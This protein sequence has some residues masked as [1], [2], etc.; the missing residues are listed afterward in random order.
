MGYYQGDYYRGDYYG[1]DPGLFGFL[2]GIAKKGLGLIGSVLPGPLGAVAKTA[3]RLIPGGRQ[4][5]IPMV[6]QRPPAPRL[7]PRQTR[8]GIQVGGQQGIQVGKTTKYFVE[9]QGMV[10]PTVDGCCPSGYHQAKDGS[11]R[12]VRNRRMNVTNPRALRRG[13]RRVSGFAKTVKRVRKA[14]RAAERA[15]G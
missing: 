9:G 12:C 10:M 6:Q 11:G 8:L 14:V 15:V 13:L 1:G 4:R 3:G 2:G 7:P 5:A